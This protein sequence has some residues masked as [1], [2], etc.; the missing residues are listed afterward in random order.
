M[1]LRILLPFQRFLD[2]DRVQ[3]IVAEGHGGSIGL[4]E[5][6]RD[7]VVVLGAGIFIYQPENGPEVCIALGEGLLV[8][9]GS[10]VTVS[11]RRA[12]GGADLA[13]LRAL[14]QREF[15]SQNEEDRDMRQAMARLEA[16][17]IERLAALPHR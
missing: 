9:A 10:E 8:K 16:G 4:L 2:T 3:R 6:R 14:V 1:R 7:C 11:A 12:T 5:H 17:L 13:D 15:R